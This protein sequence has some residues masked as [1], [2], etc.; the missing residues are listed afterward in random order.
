[1]FIYVQVQD[2]GASG[3]FCGISI[4]QFLGHEGKHS[5]VPYYSG[6]VEGGSTSIARGRVRP[7]GEILVNS[8]WGL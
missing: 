6:E 4:H 8:R 2:L 5:V 3:S 1:M 7:S